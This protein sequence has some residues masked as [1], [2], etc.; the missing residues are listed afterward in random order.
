PKI[1]IGR[2]PV[3]ATERLSEGLKRLA[4]L[5]RHGHD[6]EIR[7]FLAEFL[8]EANLATGRAGAAILHFPGRSIGRG[9]A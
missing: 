1:F 8:D 4:A 9:R 7:E 6:G 3:F 5:G 2:L